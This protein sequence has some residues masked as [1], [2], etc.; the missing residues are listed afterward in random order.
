MQGFIDTPENCRGNRNYENFF[1][2]GRYVKCQTASAALEQAFSS[3]I[4]SD[5]FPSCVISLTIN[6]AFVDVNVH[7]QKMEV[8]FS[9]EKPVFNAV[10]CAVRNT[11]MKPYAASRN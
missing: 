2:N 10:Y 1:I 8:K 6:P 5:R 3:Y 11:L 7:P 9:N 4:P